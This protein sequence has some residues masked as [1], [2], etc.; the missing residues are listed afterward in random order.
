MDKLR[1]QG[2]LLD[3]AVKKEV[4]QKTKKAE[5]TAQKI[6]DASGD[7]IDVAETPENEKF[8]KDD[9]QP[10]N[11]RIAASESEHNAIIASR[12]KAKNATDDF[13]PSCMDNFK[14]FVL[15][16]GLGAHSIFEGLA[17]G[18]E[19]DRT[20]AATFALAIGLHKGAA[21]MSLGIEFLKS[22]PD[23]PY[24]ISSLIFVFSMFTPLGIVLGMILS[25]AD[26]IVELVFT[27]LS[28]GTFLYIGCSEII[29]EEFSIETAKYWKFFAFL[30]GIAFITSL[31]FFNV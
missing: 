15:L 31:H 12:E 14:P 28:A 23:R 5:N 4:A 1:A 25:D 11:Y 22:F 9:G 17:M 7:Q 27:S 16:F 30:V 19:T 18:L 3:N 2:I 26:D 29:I 24:Y 6:A 10:Q 20:G 21:S 13:A 8:L